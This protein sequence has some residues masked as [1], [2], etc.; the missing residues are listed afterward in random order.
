MINRLVEPTTGHIWIDGK[1]VTKEDPNQLRRRVGYVI[2]Q[3]GLLPHMTI[4]QNIGLV[5]RML[6]WNKA[7]I[8]QRVSEL[9]SLVGLE[10]SV[11]RH[12]YPK[13]LSG[14]QQQRVGVARALAA[15]PP[16]LLMDEPFGAIDPIT[17]ERLQDELLQLQSRIRKTIVFVTHDVGEAIRLSD[18][19][20]IFAENSRIAQFASPLEILSAPADDF[21]RSFVGKGSAVRR[22]DLVAVGDLE[23]STQ[24]TEEPDFEISPDSSVSAALELMLEN[25][26]MNVRVSG[27]GTLSV[28]QMLSA[29][30]Q[31]RSSS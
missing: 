19:V 12:R 29:A 20:A 4:E 5:P 7:V 15:D 9:L 6:G 2:Q 18:R 10:P 27:G 1:D 17:R 31:R 25:G 26:V 21:V 11:F 28:Q 24:L 8:E 14:G 3:V 16:V 30:S 13:Q 22:L 23:A